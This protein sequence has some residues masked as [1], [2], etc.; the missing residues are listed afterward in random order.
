MSGP[1]NHSRS[2]GARDDRFTA[3][4]PNARAESHESHHAANRLR[5]LELCA[6]R[7]LEGLDDV[8]ASELDRLLCDHPDLDDERCELVAASLLLAAPPLPAEAAM[9]PEALRTR[10]L[11]SGRRWVAAHA[12]QT[13]ASTRPMPSDVASERRRVAPSAP[14]S[15]RRDR[16]GWLAAAAALTIAALAWWPRFALVEPSRAGATSPALL[17]SELV[18]EA[19]DLVRWNWTAL[20]HER[21]SAS[22]SGDV[23]WS[24]DRQEGYML[25]DGLK[26]NDPQTSQYQ[27]WIF[28]KTRD[29]RYPVDGGVFNVPEQCDQ[30]VIP[31]RAPIDVRE[32]FQFA[33]TVEPPGGVV[34]SARDL[35]LVAKP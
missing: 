35:V 12:A 7:A 22:T 9:L 2:D 24:S 33:V 34:V 17:R 1:H 4:G 20:P 13:R 19:P 6:D 26:A 8:D 27:L 11:E 25:I 10:C 30:I 31:I 32:P 23:V 21:C 28:D 3:A 5:A 15:V 18:K 16:L 29:E 14:R